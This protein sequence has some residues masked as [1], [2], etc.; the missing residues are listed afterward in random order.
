MAIYNPVRSCLLMNTLSA[1]AWPASDWWDWMERD[2]SISC[3]KLHHV[4][5]CLL[6]QQQR[7]KWQT[8][9]LNGFCRVSQWTMRDNFSN[10]STACLFACVICGVLPNLKTFHLFKAD[11]NHD[12][13]DGETQLCVKWSRQPQCC[14]SVCWS[15]EGVWPLGLI[16][17]WR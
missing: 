11:T 12:Y 2:R 14:W 13:L 8:A 17:W 7:E 10:L 6:Y 1:L 5:E 9:S 16:L 15:T 4:L 3:I